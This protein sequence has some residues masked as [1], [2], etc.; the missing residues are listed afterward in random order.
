MMR[1]WLCFSFL[2]ACYVF[3]SLGLNDRSNFNYTFY[4]F[5]R[6]PWRYYYTNCLI[7]AFIWANIGYNEEIRQGEYI[8]TET[9]QIGE[10]AVRYY[11]KRNF[12]NNRINNS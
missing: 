6:I 8:V 3:S 11:D 9:Q 1:I 7:F 5:K 10:K 2:A 4:L 12:K